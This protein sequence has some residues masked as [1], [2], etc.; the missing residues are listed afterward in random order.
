[1]DHDPADTPLDPAGAAA[2]DATGGAAK[3]A[4]PDGP[5]AVRRRGRRIHDLFEE[6]LAKEDP[7]EANFHAACADLM[8]VQQRLSAGLRRAMGSH[9]S[10]R[11]LLR[12][13]PALATN[14]NYAKEIRNY[15]NAAKELKE[16]PKRRTPQASSAPPLPAGEDPAP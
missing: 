16:G 7:L 15:T 14:L 3:Y 2:A 13:Q 4:A 5:D 11:Q 10:V 8:S 1:M 9:L 6:G 12:L